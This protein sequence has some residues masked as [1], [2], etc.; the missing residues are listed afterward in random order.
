MDYTV[1]LNDASQF[2]KE[3]IPLHLD[4]KILKDIPSMGRYLETLKSELDIHGLKER[5]EIIENKIADLKENLLLMIIGEGNF[6]KS[7][8]INNLCVKNIAPVSRIPKTWKVDLYEPSNEDEAILYWLDKPNQTVSVE[9]ANEICLEEEQKFIDEKDWKSKLYQV[10]WKYNI[11]W[12]NDNV[13]IVD[14][15]GFS[16]FRQNN[17]PQNIKMYGSTGIEV[18]TSEPFD[19]HFKRADIV[20]WVIKATKLEDRDTFN[21][22]KSIDAGSKTIIGII[23]FIDRIEISRHSEVLTKAKDLY[24]DIISDFYFMGKGDNSK[25]YSNRLKGALEESFFNNIHE[26]KKEQSSRFIYIETEYFVSMLDSIVEMYCNNQGVYNLAL[27]SINSV[28]DELKGEL[29][30]SI[31][32][33]FKE[34]KT[35]NISNLSNLWYRAGEDIDKFGK[36]FLNEG[37]D[38]E[39]LEEGL[40][41]L[42]N[43]FNHELTIG[44]NEVLGFIE[45]DSVTIGK[46]KSVN[47]K[48]N[49]KSNENVLTRRLLGIDINNDGMSSYTQ[50]DFFQDAERDGLFIA[51]LGGLFNVLKNLFGLRG[52]AIDLATKQI[53]KNLDFNKNEVEKAVINDLEQFVSKKNSD[54]KLSLKEFQG[55]TYNQ[56]ID[57][58]K[59]ADTSLEKLNTNSMQFP[60]IS[61][62][63]EKYKTYYPLFLLNNNDEKSEVIDNATEEL[64]TCVDEFHI[65]I[66]KEYGRWEE[67]FLTRYYKKDNVKLFIQFVEYGFE[68]LERIYIGAAG[69]ATLVVKAHKIEK[70]LDSLRWRAALGDLAVHYK[71]EQ[72]KFIAEIE[73]HKQKRIDGLFD[74]ELSRITNIITKWMNQ[75]QKQIELGNFDGV[76][77][78]FVDYCKVSE[79]KDNILE[80]EEELMSANFFRQIVELGIEVGSEPYLNRMKMFKGLVLDR[81]AKAENQLSEKWD[82][83]IENIIISEIDKSYNKR[84]MAFTAWE[85]TVKNK[86]KNSEF[87]DNNIGLKFHCDNYIEMCDFKL[88]SNH[89]FKNNQIN[90]LRKLKY[91]D[92]ASPIRSIEGT[93]KETKKKFKNKEARLYKKLAIGWDDKIYQI[94]RN[95]L[96]KKILEV[97]L[98]YITDETNDSVKNHFKDKLYKQLNFTI[99]NRIKDTE[100]NFV[101]IDSAEI[102]F[103]SKVDRLI[104]EQI[105]SFSYLSVDNI[106]NENYLKAID[107]NEVTYRLL[108]HHNSFTKSFVY[109]KQKSKGY[110]K[111][112][113][114]V[115]KL[116]I[117]ALIMMGFVLVLLNVLRWPDTYYLGLAGLLVSVASFVWWLI[118]KHNFNKAIDNT[119]GL[120][121][122][123]YSKELVGVI[124]ELREKYDR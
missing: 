21:A 124:K 102:I 106:L 93:L 45:L 5:S 4:S 55:S 19:Y 13:T 88:K 36:L 57:H 98:N 17:K 110:Y 91:F 122:E 23:T 54:L 8:L 24:G 82:Q 25:E 121:A 48:I 94:K 113:F 37:I 20:L 85:E 95:A 52:K 120:I 6:G 69:N 111:I 68:K 61:K 30:N 87:S 58:V 12:P 108:D 119:T 63:T 29:K 112:S 60:K 77:K 53:R 116:G 107:E 70:Y 103:K 66:D 75:E 99:G 83:N 56:V 101:K 9:E 71:K 41:D 34:H 14:T 100:A 67:D 27:E 92:D 15:P 105:P 16:Q 89:Y 3:Q 38:R 78:E 117:A 50:D 84:I 115:S 65:I 86:V 97:I 72:D 1:S 31:K 81:I 43:D 123:E 7:S 90:K 42:I 26:I 10:K 64:E 46:S 11:S 2:Y 79:G 59:Q 35:K 118:S 39:S 104:K 49:I 32:K 22:I 47:S 40:A 80:N 114:A 74:L 109:K 76:I 33:I 28:A 96:V 51:A 18:V 73:E 62:V 44:V